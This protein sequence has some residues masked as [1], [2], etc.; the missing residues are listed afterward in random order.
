V[1]LRL[2][3]E[4]FAPIVDRDVDET[5]SVQDVILNTPVSGSAR[6]TGKPQVDLVDD[7]KS[8][9]FVLTLKGTTVSRTVGQNGPA[10]IRSRS[11]T[12][13]TATKRVVYE[14]G[15]GFVAEPAKIDARTRIITEGLGSTRPGIRGRIVQR[16]A[17]PQVAANRPAAEE[18]VRQKAMRR[19]SATF[20]RQ[21]GERLD[22]LNRM[23]DMRVAIGF[24]LGGD[25]EPRYSF[26]TRNGCVQI[27]AS[28]GAEE[29]SAATVELPQLDK[30]APVQIWVHES[31][32]GDN[33]ALLLKQFDLVRSEPGDA[34]STLAKLPAAFQPPQ[35]QADPQA[36][37]TVD[38]ATAEDWIVV[39]IQ[40]SQ[41]REPTKTLAA[42]PSGRPTL[43]R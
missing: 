21:L 27:V 8:A 24:V 18:I 35:A 38:Y 40:T 12:D 7:D 25:T 10:I 16:R 43:Q 31:M 30:P 23:I 20:D 29:D 37:S 33:L 39:L 11:E 9:S 3:P 2:T 19:V 1:V 42:E 17:A 13:F 34:I 28:T 6:T 22:R 41:E 15:K 26:C 36:E 14:P 5:R 32:V 4:A